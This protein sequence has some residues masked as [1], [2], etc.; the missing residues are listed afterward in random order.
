MSKKKVRREALKTGAGLGLAAA[1]ATVFPPAGV[2]I[3][4][5]TFLR[6]ARRF[7]RSGDARDARGMVTGYSDLSS[8]DRK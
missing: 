3:A 8:S 5:G 6:S 1:V 2:A 7:A 4:A